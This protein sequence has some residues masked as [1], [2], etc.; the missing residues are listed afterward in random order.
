MKMNA[1][2]GLHRSGGC[3]MENT[4]GEDHRRRRVG[5]RI[6]GFNQRHLIFWVMDDGRGGLGVV[7]TVTR[8]ETLCFEVAR[9]VTRRRRKWSLGPLVRSY[10]LDLD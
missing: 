10:L 5:R 3:W 4:F 7:G 8:R 6:S 1:E 2:D 9:D